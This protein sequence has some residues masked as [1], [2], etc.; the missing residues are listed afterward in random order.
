LIPQA[1]I[2]IFCVDNGQPRP[3]VFCNNLDTKPEFFTLEGDA[4][5]LLHTPAEEPQLRI[6]SMLDLSAAA[7]SRVG[8]LPFVTWAF[9]VPVRALPPSST[10]ACLVIKDHHHRVIDMCRVGDHTAIF[11][12]NHGA[13]LVVDL[14][15]DSL[16]ET[17]SRARSVRVLHYMELPRSI[18][19]GLGSSGRF[20]SV[21]QNG[22][23]DDTY[24]AIVFGRIC[25]I[26]VRLSTNRDLFEVNTIHH[27]ILPPSADVN[28]FAT[29]YG[30]QWMYYALGPTRSESVH[31]TA[32][33]SLFTLTFAPMP[34]GTLEAFQRLGRDDRRAVSMRMP[35]SGQAGH[36]PQVIHFDEWTGRGV[37][38]WSTYAAP[39]RLRS[40]VTVLHAMLEVGAQ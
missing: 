23:A 10:P 13:L 40:C 30:F 4:L 25:H 21:T 9:P 15:S 1:A 39:S 6:L 34:D 37:V 26:T 17:P 38:S 24:I 5:F 28:A 29:R 2:W 22:P 11:I 12:T 19:S 31:W 3:L 20:E 14:T 33:A 16:A 8:P 7:S 36:H 35:K 32:N 27:K 18:M